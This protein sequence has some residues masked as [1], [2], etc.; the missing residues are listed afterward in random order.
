MTGRHMKRKS[1]G[2]RAVPDPMVA[3]HHYRR[4]NAYVLQVRSLV[5]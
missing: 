4:H 2:Y 3:K 5:M 1:M